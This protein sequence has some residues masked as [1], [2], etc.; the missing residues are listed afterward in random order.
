[1]ASGVIAARALLR[2][3]ERADFSSASLS[4]YET[5]IKES[6]IWQDLKTFQH[7]P[8]FLANPRLYERYPSIACDLMEQIMWVGERPKEKFSSTIVRTIRQNLL[9]ISIL[10]DL[11]MMQKI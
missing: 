5:L 6:F 10:R 11:F 4:L 7:M 8:E 1:L 3:R 9:R 2:A